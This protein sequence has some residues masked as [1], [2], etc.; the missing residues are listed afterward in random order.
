MKHLKL[1][2]ILLLLAGAAVA[3]GI[4]KLD[5]ITTAWESQGHNI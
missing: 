3:V 4:A 2:I 5:S 1:T